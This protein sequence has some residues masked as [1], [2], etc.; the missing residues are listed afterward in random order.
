ML[1]EIDLYLAEESYCKEN[2][3]ETLEEIANHLKTIDEDDPVT[4][5]AAGGAMINVGRL[6]MMVSLKKL[7][8]QAMGLKK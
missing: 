7:G 3:V 8:C 6:I 5:G 4:L 1:D 2:I